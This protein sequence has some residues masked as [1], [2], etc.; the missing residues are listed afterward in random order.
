MCV[1][2]FQEGEIFSDTAKPQE[3]RLYVGIGT[4]IYFGSILLFGLFAMLV[5]WLVER[6]HRLRHEG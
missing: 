4:A 3:T 2:F 1:A 6:A 5:R